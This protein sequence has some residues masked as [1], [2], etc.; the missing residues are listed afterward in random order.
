MEKVCLRRKK[1][2]LL[3]LPDPGW[4]IGGPVGHHGGVTAAVAAPEL[5]PVLI[6]DRR[7]WRRVVSAV[8][9]AEHVANL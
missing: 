5:V 8:P 9:A 2:L 6:T 7:L 1:P 3:L 4:E